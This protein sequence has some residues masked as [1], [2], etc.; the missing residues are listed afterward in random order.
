[1]LTFYKTYNDDSILPQLVAKLPWGHNILLIEK[2][3]DAC[4][5]Y[6]KN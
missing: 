1:M 4:S 3:K 2:I 6:L 5:G